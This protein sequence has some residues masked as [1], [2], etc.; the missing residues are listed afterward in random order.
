MRGHY[1]ATAEMSLLHGCS[2]Y[3]SAAASYPL[4]LFFCKGSVCLH[5]TSAPVFGNETNVYDSSTARIFVQ[6]ICPALS[7]V[8]RGVDSSYCWERFGKGV[9]LIFFLT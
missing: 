1:T 6:Q 8:K 2:V 4:I 5:A 3:S 9:G 7:S